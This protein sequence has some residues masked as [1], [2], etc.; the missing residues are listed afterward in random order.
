MFS[1][2][3]RYDDMDDVKSLEPD[4]VPLD[5]KDEQGMIGIFLSYVELTL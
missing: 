5:S 3:E 4:G 1:Q 2:A